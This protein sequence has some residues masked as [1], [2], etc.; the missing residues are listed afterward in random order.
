LAPDQASPPPR[1]TERPVLLIDGN[2]I[3][4]RAF[5]AL[6][7]AQ[8]RN[9]R[10]EDTSAVL[11]FGNSLLKLLTRFQ[12][13]HAAV[14]FDPPGPTFRHL[15]FEPYKQQRPPTPP[16]LIAQFAPV[17][18]LTAAL[19]LARFE[20]AGFEADDVLGSL[21]RRLADLESDVILVTTD[22]DLLQLVGARIQ[23]FDPFRDLLY[24][25]EQV[26]CRFGLL[27]GQ[28]PDFLALTGDASDNIPGVPGIGAKRARALLLQYGDVATALA[29][30]PR[31]AGCRTQLESYQALTRIRTDAP[32]PTRLDDIR[33]GTRDTPTLVR[34][35]TRLE[36]PS[37]LRKLVAPVQVTITLDR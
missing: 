12:P 32:V 34:L 30:E 36:L 37:L 3:I 2:A 17:K 28:I 29:R 11:G 31:L 13:D 19:G 26:R 1:T 25:V 20:V 24:D 27:P 5:H 9:S 15:Q 23:V 10:G 8:L 21:A 4:Y 22:K 7:R 35:L 33:L 14:A 6:H 18:E 16:D